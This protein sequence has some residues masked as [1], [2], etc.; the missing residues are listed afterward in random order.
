V[1]REIMISVTMKTT[2]FWNLMP[3]GLVDVYRYFSAFTTAI[4]MALDEWWCRYQNDLDVQHIFN[5]IYAITSQETTLFN[6]S[7]IKNHD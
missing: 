7:V 2:V 3:Y 4:L 6:I 1:I 5:I